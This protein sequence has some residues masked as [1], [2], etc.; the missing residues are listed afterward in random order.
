VSAG[1]RRALVTG[2]TRN[3]GQAIAVRLAHQDMDVLVHARRAE[4]AEPVLAQLRG[5]GVEATC[6]TADL[7]DQRQVREL[8]ERAGRV[9]VLVNNASIRPHRP[10]LEVD[11]QEWREVFAVDVEAPVLLCQGLLPGMR[12]RGWGRV[13]NFLGVRAQLGAAGRSSS[14]AAKHALVGLT[15]SLAREFGESGITVNAVS[16]GTIVTDR[17]QADSSR[18][19]ARAGISAV[20]RAGTGDEVAAAVGFLVSEDAAFITGQVLGV[21]GGELMA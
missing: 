4:Q 9:D 18:L 19:Q 15:R 2:A 6:L 11:P 17:D 21:N 3:I 10:F 5:L 8:V 12:D 13:V 14:A 20:G 7:G 1:R 16:P